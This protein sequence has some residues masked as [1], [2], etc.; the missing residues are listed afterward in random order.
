MLR[1]NSLGM[2][3]QALAAPARCGGGW[4]MT[5]NGPPFG[6]RV[7]GAQSDVMDAVRVRKRPG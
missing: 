1:R 4:Q 2:Q 3:Y 5:F 7:P 6:Q